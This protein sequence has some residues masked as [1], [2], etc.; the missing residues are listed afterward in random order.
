MIGCAAHAESEELKLDEIE[1]AECRWLDRSQVR[2]ALTCSA[3]PDSPYVRWASRA[4]LAWTETTMKSRGV[5]Y[6]VP[7]PSAIAHHLMKW[8]VES[9]M[10]TSNM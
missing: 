2:D 9:E 7:P 5:R 6:F 8:W 3:S 10:P 1:M 4:G